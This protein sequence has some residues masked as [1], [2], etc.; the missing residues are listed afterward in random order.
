MDFVRCLSIAVRSYNL[1]SLDILKIIT[2]KKK[3]QL[4]LSFSVPK[5][6]TKYSAIPAVLGSSVASE[7]TSSCGLHIANAEGRQASIKQTQ[8][9]CDIFV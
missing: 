6:L 3:E 4:T 9:Q 1:S 5:M 7:I 2:L 8:K